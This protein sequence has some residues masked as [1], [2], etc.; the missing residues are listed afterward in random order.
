MLPDEDEFLHTV[1]VLV[2]P[3][4]TQARIAVH[5][6]LELVLRHRC[7]PLAGVAQAH[8]TACLLEEIARVGLVLEPADALGADNTL[9]PL[10]GYELVEQTERERAAGVVDKRADAVFLGLA[11][12]EW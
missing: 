12:I 9:R 7:V 1:A 5:Q 2:V 10:A 6:I 8:L 11:L 3:V 4:L